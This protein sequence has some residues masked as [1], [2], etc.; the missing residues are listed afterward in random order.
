MPDE[1]FFRRP[2]WFVFIESSS[3]IWLFDGESHLDL[4]HRTE[5]GISRNSVVAVFD[6]CPKAVWEALPE[7]VRRKLEAKRKA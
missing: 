7:A 3:R 6:T 5:K 2:G 1:G 4:V